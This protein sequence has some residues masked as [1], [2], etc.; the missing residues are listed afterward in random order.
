MH[1]HGFSYPG[2]PI[3]H[4]LLWALKYINRTYFGLFGAPGLVPSAQAVKLCFYMLCRS[5][6]KQISWFSGTTFFEDCRGQ[7][8]VMFLC[9][10]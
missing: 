5:K 7:R 3:I 4:D 8:V 10:S 2:A 9:W 1:L 6:S